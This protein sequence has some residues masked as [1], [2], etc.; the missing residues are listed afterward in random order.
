MAEQEKE[1]A[2]TATDHHEIERI[3]HG[4][5]R[6]GAIR[7]SALESI[8]YPSCTV[9]AALVEQHARIA[10]SAGDVE[11]KRAALRLGRDHWE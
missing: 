10:A 8:E 1:T 11:A 6:S 4:E 9:V 3:T 2:R 7:R 5:N